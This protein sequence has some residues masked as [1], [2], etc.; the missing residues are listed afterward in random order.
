MA[1]PTQTKT[2][3]RDVVES[4]RMVTAHRPWPRSVVTRETWQR[5]ASLLSNGEWTLLGLWA[6]RQNVHM[7]V[8][9]DGN[10]AIGVLSVAAEGGRFPSVGHVHPPAIRLER[11]IRDLWHLEP[12][13][14]AD[15]RPWLDHGKWNRPGEV[16]TARHPPRPQDAYVFLPSDGESL[17]QI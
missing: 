14:L 16:E 11:A 5:A 3:L 4:G 10:K 15:T 12:E 8:L 6:D 1:E 13:G 9:D 17:H 7:A 2:C